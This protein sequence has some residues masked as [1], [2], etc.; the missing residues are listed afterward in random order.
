VNA[1]Q[2]KVASFVAVCLKLEISTCRIGRGDVYSSVNLAR[3]ALLELWS[4]PQD[5]V[6][7]AL[8]LKAASSIV[9]DLCEA[10]MDADKMRIWANFALMAALACESLGPKGA[11]VAYDHAY[12]VRSSLKMRQA[13]RDDPQIAAVI[14]ALDEMIQRDPSDEL[15][16][17]AVMEQV[18]ELLASGDLDAVDPL[19][20]SLRTVS[21]DYDKHI[22]DCLDAEIALKRGDFEQAID[23]IDELIA[24]ELQATYGARPLSRGLVGIWRTIEQ[25]IIDGVGPTD[26][27]R[28]ISPQVRARAEYWHEQIAV[29]TGGDP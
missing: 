28:V 1:Q 16:P 23:A 13:Y 18:V 2:A 21:N 24:R 6:R 29:Q 10:G 14:T 5:P 7:D 20:V 19:L 22:L 15:R 4:L 8:A 25:L 3:E 12:Q 17:S 27:L 9:V 26:Q 11:A